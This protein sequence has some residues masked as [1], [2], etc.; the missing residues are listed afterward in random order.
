MRR[1]GWLAAAATALVATVLSPREADADTMDPALARLVTDQNCRT[2]G[3]QG[4][5]YYNPSSGYTRCGTDDAAFA[6]LIAQWGFAFAPT[7][8]HPAR[9]T[10]YGGFDL[11]IEGAYTNISKDESF[12]RLGTQGKQDPTSG[13]FSVQNTSPDQFIQVYTLKTRYGFAPLSLPLGLLGLELGTKIGFQA[14]SNIGMLGA[15]VRIALLEGFRK[16]WPAIFPDLA[17]GGSVT[18]TTG[19]PEFQ[20]TVAGADAQ[21]SKPIPIGGTMIITPYVGYSFVRIFGDSGLIDL[22]PN[23]DA[24]NYCGYQGNNTPGMDQAETGKPYYDG[25]PVCGAGTSA[26]FNNTAVFDP[27]RMTRHR[28]DAGLQFRFQMVRIG[29]HFVTDVV[30]PAA[31][32]QDNGSMITRLD[33]MDSSKTITE[34][35]FQGLPKQYTLAFDVGLV[36]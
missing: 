28:I 35:K 4:G 16:G 10:G 13:L 3:P 21:I 24:L 22:T 2:P 33:P 31:A 8:M 36:L 11:A 17:V 27:V 29:A 12:W 20:M 34:N 26:D 18:T 9:S 25:Q 19:N 30:D 32:N 23:T 6:K 1:F 5:L 7:A 14:N 15:D